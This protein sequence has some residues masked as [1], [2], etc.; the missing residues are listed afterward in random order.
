M[1]EYF[2]ALLVVSLL[3]WYFNISN[4]NRCIVIN[5]DCSNMKCIKQKNL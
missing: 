1:F 2:L 5:Q 3:Y 4:E